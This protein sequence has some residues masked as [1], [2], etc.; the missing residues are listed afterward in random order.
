[1]LVLLLSK[2][3]DSGLVVL[4]PP[5]RGGT[6]AATLDAS[7][8]NRIE[9]CEGFLILLIAEWRTECCGQLFYIPVGRL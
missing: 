6:K 5:L 2:D 3:D 4:L 1:V 8:A 7:N 9:A